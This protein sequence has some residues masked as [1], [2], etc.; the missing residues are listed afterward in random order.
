MESFAALIEHFKA[1]ARNQNPSVSDIL[2]MVLEETGYQEELQSQADTEEE[3]LSRVENLEEL[4]N[5]AVSYE[6]A[7]RE[8]GQN[9][10]SPDF[11][12]K[13]LWWRIL[14]AWRKE[15]TMWC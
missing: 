6:E 5:K 9:P 13:W 12:K 11:W 2:A 14:T 4:K 3:Y 10:P 7:C 8:Q 1:E 15:Q